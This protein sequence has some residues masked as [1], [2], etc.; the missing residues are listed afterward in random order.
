MEVPLP[1]QPDTMASRTGRGELPRP[2]PWRSS[3]TQIEPSRSSTL[4]LVQWLE[5]RL[6]TMATSATDRI[7]I[8]VPNYQRSELHEDVAHHCERIYGVFLS[9]VRA[10][11][12]PGVADFPWTAEHAQKRVD[13][14]IPLVDFL[15]AFRIAQLELWDHLL[16]WAQSGP[17]H[18][19]TVLG[20]VSHVMRT[21]EAG[22]SA[23]ATTYLEAQQYDLADQENV[24]RDLVEDLLAKR[25][26]THAR[27][28]EV[29]RETGLGDGQYVVISAELGNGNG[30]TS[31]HMLTMSARTHLSRVAGGVFAVRQSEL[32][33]LL[34][35]RGKDERSLNRRLSRMVEEL[36]GR[37]ILLRVGMSSAHA[38]LTNVPDGHAEARLAFGSIRGG[39]GIVALTELSTLD[40]LV[41]R[42]DDTVGRLV[43]PQVRAFLAEDRAGDGVY[44]ESLEA[45][46]EH[47]L[48]AREAARALHVHVNT[49]YYR[50]ERIA[51]RT[52]CDLRR[53]DQ[54]IELLL[55]VRVLAAE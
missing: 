32:V 14:E 26:P 55:A 3:V 50:L 30:S 17:G 15:K 51:E 6:L 19:Q 16:E 35:L 40:Y 5:E 31:Q 7:W 38:G 4:E 13:H 10:G 36:Y 29:L 43:R 20:L 12:D 25:S 23:A 41:R 27:Q 24:Q 39:H 49:M 21:I 37:G 53:V 45:F 22:S 42:P 34:P 9:T 11:R 54:M 28:L 47:D 33:A 1:H 46:I 8:E 48:N 44:S 2:G 18:E 52:G